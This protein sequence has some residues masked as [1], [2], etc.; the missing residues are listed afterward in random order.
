VALVTRQ[1]GRKQTPWLVD[2]TVGVLNTDEQE[3]MAAADASGTTLHPST[4][5]EL[6][7]GFEPVAM[8][9]VVVGPLATDEKQIER[10]VKRVEIKKTRLVVNGE[11]PGLGLDRAATTIMRR[12]DN[13]GTVGFGVTTGPPFPAEEAAANRARFETRGVTAEDERAIA[14]AVPALFEFFGIAVKTPGLREILFK[15][16]DIPW[17]AMVTRLGNV[18][19]HIAMPGAGIR[20]A[21]AD[22]GADVVPLKISINNQ[23]ALMAEL[24]VERPH[25]P[26]SALAGITAIYAGQPDGDG[27]REA[28]VLVATRR[29]EHS[30]PT[31]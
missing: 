1:H 20:T 19:S 6:K 16:I 27:P 18:S 24:V 3:K 5:R 26:G 11:L 9:V 2:F 8:N 21:E 4:G 22:D 31:P 12:R 7:F 23:L 30:S 29:A 25:A 17:W 13:S 28:L 15:A 14:G 10:A